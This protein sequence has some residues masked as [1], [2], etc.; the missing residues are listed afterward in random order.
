MRCHWCCCFRYIR[1]SSLFS[2]F[3][4]FLVRSSILF[5]ISW[6]LCG[7]K[8]IQT[9]CRASCFK[10]WIYVCPVVCF[11]VLFTCSHPLLLTCQTVEGRHTVSHLLYRGGVLSFGKQVFSAANLPPRPSQSGLPCGEGDNEI[12]DR[13][14]DY[15][16]RST[17]STIP[18]LRLFLV[19][20]P[21]E[22][23]V[24][25]MSL[26]AVNLSL[27]AQPPP[28]HL[29]SQP[30]RVDVAVLSSSSKADRI[31]PSAHSCVCLTSSYDT[32]TR[33]ALIDHP[34]TTTTT[35]RRCH[36]LRVK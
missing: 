18:L 3:G 4:S 14:T 6:D 28:P 10:R 34:T 32:T 25:K 8:N 27:I 5:Y 15:H 7:Y 24:N 29:C 26:F 31:P 13:V 2:L 23:C 17:Y 20:Y 12:F 22:V 21:H 1:N 19:L 33:G 36:L 16:Q 30:L 9:L 11:F 35:T